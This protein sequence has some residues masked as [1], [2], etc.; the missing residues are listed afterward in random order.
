MVAYSFQR[1]FAEPLIAGTKGGTIRPNRRRH[2]RPG[3][4]LQLYVG[5]RTRQCRL[6]ARRTCIAIE[7]ISL[8]FFYGQVA[9]PDDRWIKRTTDLDAL[10]VFDGF[11]SFAEM[12]DFWLQTHNASVFHGWHIR[13]LALPVVVPR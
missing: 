9:W 5:M 10:A 13:W 4:Q 3:E 2:A 12:Q 6:I 11:R 8:D 7:P 1:R